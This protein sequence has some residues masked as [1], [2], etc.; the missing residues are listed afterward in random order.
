[1]IIIYKSKIMVRLFWGTQCCILKKISQKICVLLCWR[2]QN[3]EVF[4][5]EGD[6]E[7]KV[8]QIKGQNDLSVSK[9]FEKL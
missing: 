1:M 4:A 6:W 5:K 8:C 9:H 2:K 7:G 3:L